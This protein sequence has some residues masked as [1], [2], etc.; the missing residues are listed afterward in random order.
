M[1]VYKFGGASVKNAEGV[2]NLLRILIE[3]PL[4]GTVIVVSAMG[5]MTNAL[6]LVVEAVIRNKNDWELPFLEIKDFHTKV[7][8]DLFPNSGHPIYM[9][10]HEIFAELQHFILHTKSADH[11]YLYDQ[12]V[13]YGEILST[14]IISE[15]LIDNG[16]YNEW[17]DARDCILTDDSYRSAKVNWESSKKAILSKIDSNSIYITQG[18]IGSVEQ[19]TAS[20]T[21]GREGSDYTA[22]IF[23]YCLSSNHVTIWKDV[24]GVYNADPRYFNNPTLLERISYKEAIELAFY[25]ASVIH[26]KTLQPLQAKNIPLYVRSFNDL[27]AR[28]T[29]VGKGKGIEPKIPCYILKDKQTLLS[30]SSLDFS[31]MMEDHIGEVFKLLHRYKIKVNLIQT[32]AISFTV[33]VSDMYN[34]LEILIQDLQKYF[35]VR[36]NSDVKLYTIRHFSP[37]T[38][39]KIELDNEVLLRQQSRETL[40]LVV[41]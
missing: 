21:L 13:C 25:G 20:T 19:Q 36:Y 40:Q 27:Q 17:I 10:V 31:F 12:I 23:A 33:C 14:T 26:P 6:E 2:K 37:D 1:I 39:S 18:F 8:S 30:L 22:A 5:K 28:G 38:S 15:Y 32:S 29:C 16:I 4:C 41:R 9:K 24:L 34:N 3:K 7:I 11:A 35:R